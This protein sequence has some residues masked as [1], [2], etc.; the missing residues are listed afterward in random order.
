MTGGS[1]N[2]SNYSNRIFFPMIPEE[3]Y[4]EPG[5]KV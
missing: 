5:L 1:V 3:D 2:Y 4:Y